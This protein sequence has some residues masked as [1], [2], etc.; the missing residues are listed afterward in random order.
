MNAR[1]VYFGALIT[2][3]ALFIVLFGLRRINNRGNRMD[4]LEILYLLFASISAMDAIWGLI[5]GVPAM[6]SWHIL[7]EVVYLIT[8]S[9]TGYLWFMFTLD[10]FPAKVQRIRKNRKYFVIPVLL[11]IVMI[12]ASLRT[13]WVFSV[14]EDGTYIRGKYSMAPVAMN[15][16]YMLLGSAVALA[17][18]KDA[19]LSSHR[20]QFLVAALFPVPVLVFSAM[21][22]L[23]PPGLP[24]MEGG[25]LVGLLMYH[26]VSQ[27]DQITR[28]YLTKLPNRFA[29]EQELLERLDKSK[30]SRKNLYLLEGDLDHFK[31]INDTYGHPVGDRALLIT[32][33]V[34]TRTFQPYKAVVFRI[35]GDE[36]MMVMDSKK[37]VDIDAIRRD[38]SRHF[39]EAKTPDGIRL[40]MSLGMVRYEKGMTLL[41]MTEAVDRELYEAKR[42]SGFF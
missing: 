23:L 35:S 32:A 20:R 18:R 36:F 19:I 10:F 26:G 29:F 42:A 24:T 41:N 7:L 5:D 16:S 17:C 37:E 8:I 28:D 13:G 30:R 9:F 25:V 27:N 3:S 40:S 1:I 11:V 33:D 38:L 21:Q 31:Q 2:F 22:M 12:L 6:R 4:K 14:A 34:L 39:A 15:Y